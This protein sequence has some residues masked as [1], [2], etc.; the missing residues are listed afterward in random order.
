[1]LDSFYRPADPRLCQGDIFDDIPHLLLK[2]PIDILRKT[3]GKGRRIFWDPYPFPLEEDRQPAKPDFDRRGESVRVTAQFT[4]AMLM[5][6]DCDLDNEK[7][8][9]SIALVRPM[10]AI[11]DEADRQNVREA[12]NFAYF[13][14][15]EATE[16]GLG[17][18][19]LDFRRVTTISTDLLQVVRSPRRCSLT[20]AAVEMLQFQFIR[21]VTRKDLIARE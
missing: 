16:F 19:Y 5:T 10:T 3:T 17:E 4:R 20:A 6:F 9:W 21:F 1:V 7:H 15:P 11:A 12:R 8:A 2:P 18:A 14:L 13:Y